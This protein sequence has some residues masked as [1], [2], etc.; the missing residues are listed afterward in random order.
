MSI[1]KI[2]K[3]GFIHYGNAN[4]EM[5]RKYSDFELIKKIRDTFRQ[6]MHKKRIGWHDDELYS[7]F[8][9]Y[10][11]ELERRNYEIIINIA[12]GKAFVERRK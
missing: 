1:P 5:I 8:K 11:Y 4:I 10:A 9:E 2:E 7:M 12:E 3:D 6:F